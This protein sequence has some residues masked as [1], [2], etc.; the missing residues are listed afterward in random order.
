MLA[1]GSSPIFKSPT[2][3]FNSACFLGVLEAHL[4]ITADFFCIR[5]DQMIDLGHPLVVLSTRIP[6]QYDLRLGFFGAADVIAGAGV[7]NSSRPRLH[8]RLMVSYLYLKDAFNANNELLTQLWVKRPT[9]QVL[10]L[11]LVLLATLGLQPLTIG[12]VPK[13]GAALKMNFQ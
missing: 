1:S 10:F 7:F 5:L 8:T 6:W 13:L 3:I 9:W 12:Q 4:P 11:Q 2:L